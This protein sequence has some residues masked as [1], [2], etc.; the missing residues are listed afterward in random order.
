M[1]PMSTDVAIGLL[2]LAASPGGLNAIQFTSKTS[3]SY[4]YSATLLFLLSL[5]AVL[6][7]PE[8]RLLA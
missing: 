3:T 2:L 1:I 4:S 8:S 5:L 6:V 7:S